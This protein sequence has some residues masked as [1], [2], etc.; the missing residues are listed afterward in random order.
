MIKN[1]QGSFITGQKGSA[2]VIHNSLKVDKE[3]KDIVEQKLDTQFDKYSPWMSSIS[4]IKKLHL[5]KSLKIENEFFLTSESITHLVDVL[6]DKSDSTLGFIH[7]DLAHQF[8]VY[9]VSDPGF[10]ENQKLLKKSFSLIK[11][12]D[13]AYYCRLQKMVLHV[14]MQKGYKD[15]ELRDDGTGLS[16]FNY[17]KGI[18]LS[19]PT[20]KNWEFELILNIAHELGHQALITLQ[21]VDKIILDSHLELVYSV[22]RKTERPAILSFHALTASIYMLEFI[23]TN[24]NRIKVLCSDDY[25]YERFRCIKSDVERGLKIFKD[26]KFS[27]LGRRIYDEFV[28][29]YI[30][31]TKYEC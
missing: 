31:S 23:L 13:L 15:R 12:I 7:K 30:E 4:N 3:E 10:R 29:L 8:S 26:V 19:V 9:N 6:K 1:W 21:K 11:D 5:L 22:V 28:A 18:F 14:I 17:R 16:S 24:K 20:C 27:P 25:F 2:F